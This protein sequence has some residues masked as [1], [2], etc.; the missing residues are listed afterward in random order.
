MGRIKDREDARG[1]LTLCNRANEEFGPKS[2][3][4]LGK[5]RSKPLHLTLVCGISF[6]CRVFQEAD[7]EAYW[8]WFCLMSGQQFKNLDFD[9]DSGLRSTRPFEH[10][11][12]HSN[13]KVSPSSHLKAMDP[14]LT[15][16]QSLITWYCM[17][18]L[19]SRCLSSKETSIPTLLQKLPAYCY[20]PEAESA[21]SGYSTA[22]LVKT[23]RKACVE[24]RGGCEVT[25]A[26]PGQQ[27]DTNPKSPHLQPS[28]FSCALNKA[29][30]TQNPTAVY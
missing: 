19:S 27:Q 14:S 5:F 16:K 9:Q 28:P 30:A 17:A 12:W 29:P 18:P 13:N 26:A 2:L 24:L 6:P 8:V 4:T 22:V 7:M 23:F 21:T 25:M 10:H 15:L 20:K 11:C 1:G 3:Q